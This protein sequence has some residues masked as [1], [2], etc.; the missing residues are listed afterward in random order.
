MAVTTTAPMSTAGQAVEGGA[1]R[2]AS[3]L[4]PTP[5]GQL[6]ARPPVVEADRH[7]ARVAR[8]QGL[9]QLGR[10]EGG[11][12]EHHP[13]DPVVEQGGGIGGAAHA[14]ARLHPDVD[15]CG[16]LQH[17]GAVHRLP[18]ARRVEVDD[19]DPRAPPATYERASA[20]G[21]P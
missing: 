7:P 3:R 13:L 1:E 10:L 8:G 2:R 6:G 15:G 19:M 16:D 17:H 4:L 20:T 21:S 12:A 14:P 9:D 5:H 18:G 11:G